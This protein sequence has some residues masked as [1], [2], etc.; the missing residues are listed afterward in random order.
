[1]ILQT[2]VSWPALPT[3]AYGVTCSIT[4]FTSKSPSAKEVDLG[5]EASVI[6]ALRTSGFKVGTDDFGVGYSNLAYLEN[7]QLDYIKIDRVFV[8][9]AF[10]AEA[11][12]EMID[13]I[14]GVGKARNL[15]IIAEGIERPEQQAQLLA[16]GVDLGQGLAVR[17]S[18]P[19]AR[20]SETVSGIEPRRGP[21]P[22][23]RVA[24][25]VCF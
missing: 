7:F 5:A 16:R 21:Q 23:R 24:P 17:E 2:R 22:G 9:N 18:D 6:A 13:H 8:A 15:Q 12:S 25:Y 10:R 11:G 19:G 1:V 3:D 4:R 14:I 20:V